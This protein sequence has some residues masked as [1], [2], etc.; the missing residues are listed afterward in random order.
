[1]NVRRSGAVLLECIVAFGLLAVM[2]TV[3]VQMLSLTSAGQRATERRAIALQEA[4]NIMERV[5]AVSWSEISTE[6]LGEVHLAP[7]VIRILPDATLELSVEP[8]VDDGPAGKHISL[9]IRWKNPAGD[10]ESPVRLDYWAFQ[11]REATP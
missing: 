11:S 10:P 2:A 9:A 8:S 3:C 6:R 7:D 5:T 1:M 4:A